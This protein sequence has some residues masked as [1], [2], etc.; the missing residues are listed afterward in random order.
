MTAREFAKLNDHEVVG[1]LKKI[2]VTYSE[3]NA[4]KGDFVESKRVFYIDEAGN[5][6]HKGKEWCIITAEG[7]VI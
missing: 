1:K 5:E 4:L 2:S 7:A 6:Y 3:Y